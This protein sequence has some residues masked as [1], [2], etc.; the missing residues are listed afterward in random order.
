MESSL[1]DASLCPDLIK[2]ASKLTI[3]NDSME[4]GQFREF[5][6]SAFGVANCFMHEG[7]GFYI[8]HADSEGFN[9]RAACQDAQL[10]IRQCLVWVK[11]SMVMGRQ[12]YHWAHEP[13]LYGWKVGGAHSWYADRKQTTIL[14]FD[15]PSRSTE[16]PTMKP[17]NLFEYQMKNSSKP[18]DIVL[19][20]FGGSG[21]TMIAAERLSRKAYLMELSPAYCDVIISRWQNHTGKK[22]KLIEA[23]FPSN[24]V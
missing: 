13:C 16:H 19:D 18:G 6:A 17:V 14:E 5:L 22:A 8:W 10:Q 9:F 11:N 1:P 3:M 4:A 12:D 2:H 15:R 21:T 20:S 7:A 23:K 24:V